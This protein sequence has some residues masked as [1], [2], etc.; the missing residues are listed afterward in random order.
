MCGIV[1]IVQKE[2]CFTELY[3][4]LIMLQHRGQDAAG[5]TICDNG[6]LNS[7]KSKGLVNEVFI[8]NTLKG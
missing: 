6:K 4:S 7:R 3:D 2:S 5:M 1:G 8:S